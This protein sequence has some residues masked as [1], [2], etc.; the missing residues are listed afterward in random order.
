[1]SKNEK[2]RDFEILTLLI[3]F[4]LKLNYFIQNFFLLLWNEY[5]F[6]T[7][8]E[9]VERLSFHFFCNLGKA[10]CFYI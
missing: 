6:I 3:E 10:R 8:T 1:M 7:V 5:R 2:K 9:L 4:R